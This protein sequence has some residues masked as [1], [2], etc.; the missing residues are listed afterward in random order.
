MRD[1]NIYICQ[2]LTG[3]IELELYEIGKERAV[4]NEGILDHNSL[5]SQDKDLELL[6]LEL[7]LELENELM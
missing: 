4:I 3:W 2:R 7:I 1:A 6:I 5:E